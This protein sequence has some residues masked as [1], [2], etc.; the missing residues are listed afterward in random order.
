MREAAEAIRADTTL[1]SAQALG[2]EIARRVIN[3]LLDDDRNDPAGAL[4]GI[5]ARDP[6]EMLAFAEGFAA[7]DEL[8]PKYWE[9]VKSV[10][11][12]GVVPQFQLRATRQ[13]AAADLR[14]T[15]SA[16]YSK[17]IAGWL[18]QTNVPDDQK[19]C[20]S[21]GQ[22]IDPSFPKRRSGTPG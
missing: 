11:G 13:S 9:R 7:A 17:Q 6:I 16:R 19:V 10:Y 14:K 2:R 8:A 1:T 12:I 3:L 22:C 20:A 21:R 15:L 5:A 4:T 18:S